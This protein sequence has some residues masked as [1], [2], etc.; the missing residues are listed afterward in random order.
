MNK[1]AVSPQPAG[2][3]LQHPRTKLLFIIALFVGPILLAR[4]Y[5]TEVME[6]GPVSTTNR[7][8]LIHPAR[9]VSDNL[10]QAVSENTPGTLLQDKWTLLHMESDCPESCLNS[11]YHTRQLHYALNKDMDRVQRVMV[12]LSS[13]ASIAGLPDLKARHPQLNLATASDDGRAS[14]LSLFQ[15][16]ERRPGELPGRIYLLDPM[17]NLLMWYSPDQDPRDILKDLR[18]LLKISQI[19]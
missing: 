14:L 19:G 1:V 6:S 15:V 2:N 5:F 18:K 3:V 4:W 17:G 7:G 16:D 10:L 9:P 13:G 12:D 8:Q 11:L